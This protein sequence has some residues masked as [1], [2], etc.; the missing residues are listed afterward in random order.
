MGC[1]MSYKAMSAQELADHPECQHLAL[2][3][4]LAGD[5]WHRHCQADH[6]LDF[7]DLVSIGWIALLRAWKKFDPLRGFQFSTLASTII[8]RYF[9][10]SF[11]EARSGP[12]VPETV[13]SYAMQAHPAVNRHRPCFA[14]ALKILRGQRVGMPALTVP[15]DEY[16]YQDELD[17]LERSLAELSPLY[18]HIIR[19][20]FFNNE[21]LQK[22]GEGLGVTRE[23]ARQLK[24]KALR[25]LAE[26]MDSGGQEVPLE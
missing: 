4:K 2:L 15:P 13:R 26:K 20:V 12:R 19:G 16:P 5:F 18:E 14:R 22:L 25:V 17:L 10:K 7:E 1:L 21:T 24:N 23:R 3:H 11:N 6:R 9:W 8:W